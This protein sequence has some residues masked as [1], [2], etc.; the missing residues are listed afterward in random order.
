VIERVFAE[1]VKLADASTGPPPVLAPAGVKYVI[2][3]PRTCPIPNPAPSQHTAA[4]AIRTFH[5]NR[6]ATLRSS[7]L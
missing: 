1:V 2:E 4:P 6:V 7:S 3:A 5:R